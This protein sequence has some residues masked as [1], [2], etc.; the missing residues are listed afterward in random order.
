[1]ILT[2]YQKRTDVA[3]LRRAWPM[4][5][6]GLTFAQLMEIAG[7]MGLTGRPL[8]LELSDLK[9]LQLPCVLH[10]R[11]DHFVVLAQVTSRYAEILDPAIGRRRLPLSQVSKRFSGAALEL[12][13]A[14]SFTRQAVASRLSIGR[15]FA[16]M[17][18]LGRA[19]LQLFCLSVALQVFVLVTPFYSQVVIDDIVVSGD[20]DL[21]LLCALAFSG[22]AISIAVTSGFRSW[23]IIYISS[24]LNFSW[25]SGLFQHLLSLPCDYFEKRHIGDIQSRFG[26]LN[27]IRD[28]LTRQAVE[29]IIDGLMAVTTAI[30][31][32]MY[33]PALTVIVVLS[34]VIHVLVQWSLLGPLRSASLELIVR[35]ATRETFFLETIRGILAIKNFGN[36]SLRK[37]GYENRTADSI[38]AAADAGRIR[39]W[40]EIASALIFGLLNVLLIWLGA[41]AIVAG[42]FTVGMMVA[43]LAYKVHFVGRSAGLVDKLLQFRLAGIH[44]ERIADIVEAPTEKGIGPG[45]GTSTFDPGVASGRIEVRDIWYRYG[46]NEPYVISGLSLSVAPGEHVAIAGPSGSGKSTLLKIL[47][48]LT[49]P[50]RGEVLVDGRPLRTIDLRSYRQNIG[51]VMQNDALLSGS[52]LGNIS[53]FTS[54][55][56]LERVEE[57][58][59]LAGI[60]D[61]IV[62]M[63][64]GY[65]TLVGDMGDVLSG[66]QKQRLLLARALYRKPRILFLDEATSHLDADQERHLVRKV[67]ALDITRIVIAHRHETLRHAERVIT[68]GAPRQ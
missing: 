19:L 4:S 46:E 58:C 2:F 12:R 37:T 36:E 50:E 22:L 10:W 27:A 26:S 39:V 5:M 38:V 66:G 21:L 65:Y 28:L 33:S 8:R 6:K 23:V 59:R 31:M 29:A 14:S 16:N 40:G 15:F 11:L 44:L 9:R 32:Y 57:C 68:L 54:R 34:V 55:P 7:A 48:G 25:S 13:P 20:T 47:I 24:T 67:S 61:D 30:V 35:T 43:F 49:V 42:T 45:A 18:G 62:S 52:L 64:M 63:P 56:N 3:A 51:V 17:Q 53:F 1:M 60:E 41:H